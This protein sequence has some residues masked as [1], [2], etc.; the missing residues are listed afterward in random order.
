M[1]I[2]FVVTFDQPDLTPAT[3][4]TGI[5]PLAQFVADTIRER[6]ARFGVATPVT[7]VW[8]PTLQQPLHDGKP[9]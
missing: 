7:V 2:S 4:N 6:L 8:T 1:R 3:A 9:L 5:F